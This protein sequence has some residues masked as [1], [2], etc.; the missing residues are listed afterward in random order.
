MH[1]HVHNVR[2][3]HDSY[4]F[5]LDESTHKNNDGKQSENLDPFK[6]LKNIRVS[7]VNRLIIGQLNI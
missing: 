7:N 3:K 6:L 1:T 5:V 2:S 4:D